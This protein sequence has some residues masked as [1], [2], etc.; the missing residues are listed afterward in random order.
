VGHDTGSLDLLALSDAYME[1]PNVLAASPDYY[2]TLDFTPSD[3]LFNRDYGVASQRC[4]QWAFDSAHCQFEKAWDITRGDTNVIVV[5]NDAGIHYSHPDLQSKLW[6]NSPEDSNQNGR[7]EPW[8]SDST[9][10]GIRGDLDNDDDDGN[11]YKDDVIGGNFGGYTI[12]GDTCTLGS[13][14][15]VSYPPCEIVFPLGPA[16]PIPICEGGGK[17]CSGLP[18]GCKLAI[19][20]VDSIIPTGYSPAVD[21]VGP[22]GKQNHGTYVA[23]IAAAA[24]NDTGI[25]GAAPNCRL[26][27]ITDPRGTIS[28]NVGGV[29]YARKMAKLK[30]KKMVI[31][32][33]WSTNTLA[34]QS[35][36]GEFLDSLTQDS[37]VAVASAGNT[38]N[39]I[40]SF[41]AKDSRVIAVSGLD[42]GDVKP[43]GPGSPTYHV[44]IDLSAPWEHWMAWAAI[45]G[46]PPAYSWSYANYTFRTSDQ[47]CLAG[48]ALDATGTSFSAP[49]VAGAAALIKSVYPQ[50]NNEE[51]RAKLRSST[52]SIYHIPDN[53]GFI[54]KLGTGRLNAFKALTFFGNIPN[55]S[56]DTTLKGT[57]YVSGDIRV[58]A[59]KTLRLDPG[60]VFR[61]YPGDVMKQLPDTVKTA[62]VVDSGG[63]LFINGTSTNPEKF[64]SLRKDPDN[65][66]PDS[67]TTYDWRGIVVRPGGVFACSN[68]VIRHA[69]AGIEDSSRYPHMIKNVRIGRCKMYGILAVD[70]DSLTIRGC[71]IDSVNA[72]PGGY[73]IKVVSSSEGGPRLV[74]DTVRNSFYG[75]WLTRTEA[76]VDSCAVFGTCLTGIVC[77]MQWFTGSDSGVPI[78][79]TDITGY[80]NNQHFQNAYKG[81]AKL[82]NC[83]L[84][85]A[86]S[87]SR[88]P[89]GIRNTDGS[90]YLKLRN[91][92]VTQWNTMGVWVLHNNGQVTDLG[93]VSSPVD[94]GF[95]WIYTG[96][97]YSSWKYVN[98]GDCNGCSTPII[99]AEY[100]CWAAVN[101]SSSR[102]SSNI[103][104]SPVD[105]SCMEAPKIV[106]G[107]GETTVLPK[108]TELFQNYP[109]PFNPTTLI[110][111]NLE[112]PEKVNLEI[113]NILGQKVRT[114]LGGE[115]FAAGPYTF[116][117]D[118]KDNR[119][120]PLSSGM[121]FYRLSTPS[122][123]QTKKM[124][125]VK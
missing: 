97:S 54:G 15:G 64:V 11:G 125:L 5:I 65:G 103:D 121:Y 36:L 53:Q 56:N 117:W 95:N 23:S 79:A 70:T 21:S 29:I 77:E 124:A 68:A 87:P 108:P 94:S 18:T 109:N 17:G 57:V 89:Y 10:N 98:D 110:Q 119:G 39:Q 25:V 76:P 7:F 6:I 14:P 84:V 37:I 93:S 35:V 59:G 32:M 13:C 111:F 33:S 1:D 99:K 40:L 71:R 122:F 12:Y 20:P 102:F 106:A 46:N 52:D 90:T 19:F 123:L 44:D 34:Q 66:D 31:N 78:T 28:G 8:P 62:I 38:D 16:G 45:V 63:K 107:G 51:V 105:V 41:P 61:F 114:I 101:P 104:R 83:K 69:Y 100:N 3:P 81:Q 43:A 47:T 75:I 55:S 27:A 60:T 4:R 85:S 42:T 48:F 73:G 26:L 74:K 112:K 118:G 86:T 49:L 67:A 116:L 58:R 50:F 92:T 115:E 91:S 22:Q 9:F 2:V 96:S 88:S 113:F 24:A 82:T 120:S 72:F 80:Y 30:N